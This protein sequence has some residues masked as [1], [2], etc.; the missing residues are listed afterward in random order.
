MSESVPPNPYVGPRSLHYGE[1]IFG[2]E[3][4]ARQLV[5][6]LIAE[7]I[8]LL[9]SPSGAGKTSLI[10]AALIRAIERRFQILPVMRVSQEAVGEVRPANRYVFSALLSLERDFPS[11]PISLDELGRMTFGDYLSRREAERAEK[12]AALLI[13]DQFEEILTVDPMKPDEKTE[14]FNQVGDAMRDLKRWALFSMREDHVAALD[15]YLR[16]IP[17]RL[18]ATFRLDL[19]NVAGARAAIEEPARSMGVTFTPEATGKLVDDLREVLVRSGA[20]TT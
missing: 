16:L 17:T 1:N 11:N 12:R 5:E 10:E 19:L 8:V 6:L 9:Y 2:R 18:K 13:F 7:R 4:E 3:R 14:F 20:G 15:P